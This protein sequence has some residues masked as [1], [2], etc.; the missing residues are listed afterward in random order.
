MK[1]R[2]PIYQMSFGQDENGN[3]GLVFP[4]EQENYGNQSI[5]YVIPI[6]EDFDHFIYP[7]DYFENL[8]IYFPFEM[9][10]EYYELKAKIEF[11][12]LKFSIPNTLFQISFEID[13][14]ESLR[15][16]P[17]YFRTRLLQRPYGSLNYIG[18]ESKIITKNNGFL[19][20]T[21]IDIFEMDELYNEYRGV[22]VGFTP[23][24][25]NSSE[26]NFTD[27]EVEPGAEE[28]TRTPEDTDP[29]LPVH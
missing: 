21:P 13:I 6:I 28:D 23:N 26:L 5:I 18:H 14:N 9:K 17:Y 10:G 11:P 27:R 22:F 1:T 2:I 7:F 3:S 29:V 12:E 8:E 4:S 20:L 24:F 15:W 25:G 16:D 19:A